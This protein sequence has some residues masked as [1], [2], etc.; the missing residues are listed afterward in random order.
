MA[1]FEYSGLDTKGKA[2]GGIVD[3]ESAK[4][5]RGRL[6]KQG[7]FVTE[8]HEQTKKATRGSGLNVEIDFAQYFQRVTTSDLASMTSQLATLIG[9]A[10]PMSESLAALV[11]QSEK[12]KL[13][14]VLSAVKEKVNEGSGLAEALADHPKVFNN[15]FIQ[16]VR[17]GERSGSLDEVL[18]RL[19]AFTEA[20]VRLQ[21]KILSAMIY[22]ILMSVVGVLILLGLFIGVIPR[23]RELFRDLPGGE[24]ALPFITRA[25]F[26]FGDILLS[27][28]IAV[29]LLL[30]AGGG[31]GFRRWI[32]TTAGRAWWDGFRLR[33]PVF[34]GLTRKVAV[35]RFCRTL[36]TLLLSGVPILQAMDIVR[37]VVD[38]AVIAKAIDAATD[39]I[40]EGQSIAAP[41]KQSG[42][43]PAIVTHMIAVG[44][45]TGEIE[46]MLNSVADAYE[47][48][49]DRAIEAL[50]SLLAPLMILLMGGTVMLVAIA[51]LL[52]MMSISSMIR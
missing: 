31:L 6:R 50:T 27:P 42:Q 51:L 43:F 41:L 2:V 7:V 15:L 20:A 12:Q 16:M 11:D 46:R 25:V 44:E 10:V 4:T 34:G 14:V 40:R 13:K 8:I 39:N 26:F 3:A 17:A 23:I 48:E 35:A 52:P 18:R 47:I 29:I 30:V 1:V 33:L 5:A 9:A 49:V 28:W 21:G 45:K 22:P 36:S 24:E 32:R 37:N 19:T 38:N